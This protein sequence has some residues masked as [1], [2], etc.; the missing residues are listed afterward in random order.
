M[1]T[2]K[3]VAGGLIIIGP[4]RPYDW[5]P[6]E[7]LQVEAFGGTE[8]MRKIYIL[9]PKMAQ[10]GDTGAHKNPARAIL[11]SLGPNMLPRCSRVAQDSPKWAQKETS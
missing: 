4:S 1:K 3:Q 6:L 9:G 5:R 11:E 2:V 7:A 10:D 8:V